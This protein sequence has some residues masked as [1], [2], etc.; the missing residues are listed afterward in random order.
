MPGGLWGGPLGIPKEPNWAL[1]CAWWYYMAAVVAATV[2]LKTFND[3]LRLEDPFRAI[4]LMI[5]IHRLIAMSEAILYWPE[6]DD[7]Y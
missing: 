2:T 3:L 4:K 6:W 5:R 7:C 1:I